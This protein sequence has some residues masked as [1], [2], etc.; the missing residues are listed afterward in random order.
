MKICQRRRRYDGRHNQ[1]VQGFDFSLPGIGD[2]PGAAICMEVADGFGG[3]FVI[4]QDVR[5]IVMAIL[6]GPAS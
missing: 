2:A 4:G 1:T 5:G 6:Y 3:G